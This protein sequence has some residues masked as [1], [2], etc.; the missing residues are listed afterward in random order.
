[1]LAFPRLAPAVITLIERDDGTALLARN[2][3]WPNRMYSCLAGFV[4]PGETLEEAVRREVRE[5]VGIE[6]EGLRYH[7]SQP[8]PFPHSL[9]L[10]FEARYGSGEIACDGDE[11]AYARW[12]TPQD[13][14]DLPGPVSI[15]RR[16]IDAWAARSTTPA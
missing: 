7:S 5:E 6:L 3:R 1:L 10:G 14:P 13:L 12:F 16:L 8:W 2:A 11:I 9:M 15:A 4:E